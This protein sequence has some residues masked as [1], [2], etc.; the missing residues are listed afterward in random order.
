MVSLYALLATS[1]LAGLA[2]AQQ[3]NGT[4]SINPG[5]VQP[6]ERNAWCIAQRNSCRSLC[7]NEIKDNVCTQQ[8]LKFECV[9]SNGTTPDLGA[10]TDTI[11]DHAC[12]INYER[13]LAGTTD[14]DEQKK[15]KD[16]YNCATA[17]PATV[18]KPAATS[19]A[20]AESSGTSE[21]AAA[22][23][24][25]SEAAEPSGTNAASTV[26]QDYGV[27]ILAAALLATFGLLL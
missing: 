5:E 1:I 13:C 11:P 22:T 16:Q 19:S 3:T 6:A 7:Y 4:T 10:W 2:A 12:Q 25:A 20:A 21:T 26:G 8:D 27:G 15:C 23:T 14:S 17:H 9:C 24:T 18:S